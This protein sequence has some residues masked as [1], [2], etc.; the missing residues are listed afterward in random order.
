MAAIES[1][2]SENVAES[3]EALSREAEQL[4]AKLDEE[5]SK[6]SDVDL[7][8]VAQRLESMTNFTMK[9][10][11][12]LKGHQGKVLCMDWSADKRHMVSSS[13]DGKMLVWDAFTTNKEHAITMPTTWVMACA[14]GPS[15]SVVACGGLDNRCTL[16]P[17]S[18]DEDPAAKKRVIA[19]H[20]SYL[21]CCKFTNS[22][23]QILTG[24][25]DSSCCLWDVESGQMMQ[26]F[27][28]HTGDVMSLDLSPSESGNTFVSGS[29][30]KTVIVWD[31]RTGQCV[32]VFE[33]HESDINSVR[34]YP[35][36]DAIATGS[37]DA[38][39][40]SLLSAQPALI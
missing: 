32:Q 33:G 39:V 22:D 21:S 2:R 29:C 7:T 34:F 1:V 14:Y 9:P 13:Q 24:S 8:V 40:G 5:R 4:K 6:L 30:D 20:T 37:D 3:I 19:T 23:Q 31:M 38:T 12:V 28:G 25:G 11:R 10:R 15:G 27:I 26:S 16:Y 17:L 36:G 35:S 18:L